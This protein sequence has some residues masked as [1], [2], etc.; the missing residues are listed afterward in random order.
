MSKFIKIHFC[1]NS[2]KTVSIQRATTAQQLVDSLVEK[3][4]ITAEP[5]TFCLF[6]VRA[7]VERCIHKDEIPFEILSVWG[8]DKSAKFLFKKRYYMT[9]Q[10]LPTA[11]TDLHMLY[12]QSRSDI[13]S[14]ELSCS[15]EEVIALA[16]LHCQ[17]S[18]GDHNQARHVVGFLTRALH[19]YVP[20]TVFKSMEPRRWEELIFEQ[21][22][23]LAG[24]SAVDCMK[25]FLEKCKAFT[26]YG[27]I[28]FPVKWA[29][30]GSRRVNLRAIIAVGIT[31]VSILRIPTKEVMANHP[32]N[33]ILSWGCSATTFA[34][35][36]GDPE[37]ISAGIAEQ[38]KFTFE[39]RKGN[40]IAAALQGYVDL[41]IIQLSKEDENQDASAVVEQV[42][43]EEKPQKQGQAKVEEKEE[44]QND[45]EDNA[46]E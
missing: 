7:E 6:E 41:L 12:I 39:T 26:S 25:S 21:H 33:D 10:V 27:Q 30:E 24:K 40:E 2:S 43:V 1:D 11:E 45:V 37:T 31:G 36:V 8:N 15:E 28:L 18:F 46:D 29:S 42:S 16:G 5:E 32:F 19:D 23:K 38:R 35:T 9:P 22:A 17:I 4:S 3:L 20:T 44:E 13:L 14:G 34:F